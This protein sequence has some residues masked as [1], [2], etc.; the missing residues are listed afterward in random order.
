MVPNGL[1]PKNRVR[2]SGTVLATK[3]REDSAQGFNPGKKCYDN[4]PEGA[5][6][7]GTGSATIAFCPSKLASNGTA[8]ETIKIF[9]PFRTDFGG[10][11]SQ[12]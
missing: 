6:V 7:A 4:S 10:A 8:G 9:R 3:W 12:G 2:V 1:L 11:G 5:S